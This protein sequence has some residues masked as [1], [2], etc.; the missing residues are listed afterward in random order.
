MKGP[1]LTAYTGWRDFLMGTNVETRPSLALENWFGS[2]L[3]TVDS[4][5]GQPCT[6]L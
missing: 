5:L 2:G 6:W 4:R 1:Y 3:A